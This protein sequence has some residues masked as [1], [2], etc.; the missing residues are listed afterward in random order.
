MNR[1]AMLSV[2]T[3]PLA[4]LGGKSTGGMNVYVRELSRELG[5][6]GYVVDIF[7]RCENANIEPIIQ[8]GPG[9]RVVHVCAGPPEHQ[10]KHLL[11]QYLPEFA[12]EVRRF[13]EQ[14]EIA[15][16]VI[17]SHYWLSGWV[18]RELQRTL[19]VPIIQMFHTLG[20]M[21]RLVARPDEPREHPLRIET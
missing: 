20:E 3:C 9:V 2:H 1:I 4:M 6:R 21:K 16:D 10:D 5:R 18:A 13:A 17:H 11:Y 12:S 7:T 14:Q 15:Y 19:R 8:M